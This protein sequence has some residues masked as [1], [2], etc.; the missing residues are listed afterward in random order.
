MGRCHL[1]IALWTLMLVSGCGQKAP[2]QTDVPSGSS[3][4]QHDSGTLPD[5]P[6]GTS[7]EGPA[8]PAPPAD[9]EPLTASEPT[10]VGAE[11]P[12]PAEAAPIPRDGYPRHTGARA[13]LSGS[14]GDMELTL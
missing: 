13:Q 3:T 14:K 7:D 1:V 2:Q 12:P 4:T 11:P 5:E 6:A 10:E 9:D 8:F